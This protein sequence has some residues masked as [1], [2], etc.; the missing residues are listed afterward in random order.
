MFG[1]LIMWIYVKYWMRVFKVNVDV[2]VGIFL[3]GNKFFM[4]FFRIYLD[5]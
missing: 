1:V 4:S 3:V 2:I 5:E